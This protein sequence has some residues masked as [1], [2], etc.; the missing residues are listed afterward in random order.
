VA[1]QGYEFVEWRLK[2]GEAYWGKGVASLFTLDFPAPVVAKTDEE[3]A[4][5]FIFKY[6]NNF[7]IF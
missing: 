1:L 3:N 4:F 5:Q 7:A 2:S 6:K